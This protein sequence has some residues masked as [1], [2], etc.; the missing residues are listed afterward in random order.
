VRRARLAVTAVFVLLG[1]VNG[2]LASRVPAIKG[3]LHLS[4]GGLGLA[5]L[6]TALG[7]VLS[8]PISGAVL[9][10]VAPR[11]WIAVGLVPFAV[12]LPLT[13]LAG[14]RWSLLGVLAVFGFGG[15]CVD[16]AMNTEATRV[17]ALTGRR[18]LS[19]IHATYSLGA[20]VGAGI[21]AAAAATSVGFGGQ[22]VAVDAVVLVLGL[23]A[24]RWLPA[25]PVAHQAAVGPSTGRG[26]G[27]RTRALPQLRWPL[28]ALAVVSFAGLLCEGAT[29]DWSAVYIHS[30]LGAP[31]SVGALGYA[32]FSATMVAS[33]L[34][35]DRL[36]TRW[37]P[38]RVVR[39]AALVGAVGLGTALLVG[40]PGVAI[41]GFAVL[42]FGLAA[43]FPLAISAAAGL[44]VAG[45]SVALVTS[46]GYLGLLCGPPLIG[47]LATL[48]SLPVALGAVVVLCAVVAGLA[49]HLRSGDPAERG[50]EV[51]AGRA[52]A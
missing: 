19:G 27:G 40:R 21:G 2:S 24:L 49:G 51:S 22:F 23:G 20:L 31:A 42:G 14:G 44:G 30:T 34:G 16:V 45:P 15:G 43:S 46:C 13:T 38:V 48:S 47:G 28:V 39:V 5:L 25:T 4:A 36:T 32:A 26:R 11:V 41:A 1:L 3:Q 6:G 7:S 9:A 12:V 17:Q 52:P 37:G 33:R 29:N 18:I 50:A 8:T 10:R 35:G